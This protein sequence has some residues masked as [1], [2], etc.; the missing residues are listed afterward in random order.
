MVL[1]L[2]ILTQKP[3]LALLPK[4]IPIYGV[5]FKHDFQISNSMMLK[6]CLVCLKD[7]KKPPH[8]EAPES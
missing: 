3:K 5:N 8:M 4:L 7:S 6:S 1:K 2:W